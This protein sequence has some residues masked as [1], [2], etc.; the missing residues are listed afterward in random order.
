MAASF[1]LTIT[2]C[3]INKHI[4]LNDFNLGLPNLVNG[5]NLL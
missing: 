5:G 3:K 4:L 1:S 2:S